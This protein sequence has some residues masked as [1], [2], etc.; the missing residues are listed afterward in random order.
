MRVHWNNIGPINETALRLCIAVWLALGSVVILSGCGQ[1][2]Q[3]DMIRDLVKTRG[4]EVMDNGVDNALYFVCDVATIGSIRRRF[5][6]SADSARMYA[7][8]CSPVAG[9]DVI[10][11][12]PLAPP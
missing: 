9:G 11:S 10:L 6:Q 5:G 12:R 4:A 3:G 8:L 2:P 1:T 7:Q